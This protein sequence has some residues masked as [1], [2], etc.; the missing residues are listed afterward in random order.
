MTVAQRLYAL[1]LSVGVGFAALAA[2]DH[3]QMAEVYEEANYS[4]S[5]SLPS[6]AVLNDISQTFNTLR[7]WVSRHILHDDPVMKLETESDIAR[8]RQQLEESYS[9]YET[10][11]VDDNDRALLDNVK[12]RVGNYY[13][14]MEAILLASRAGDVA[15]ARDLYID[16]ANEGS[17]GNN[18]INELIAYNSRFA[19]DKAG[20]AHQ[21]LE[22]TNRISLVMTGLIALLMLLSGYLIVRSLMRQLGGEPAMAADV[23]NR[24]ARGDVSSEIR[25]RDGDR[26]SLMAAMH[27]MQKAIKSVI[28]E[29]M[30]VSGEYRSGN[31]AARMDANRFDGSFRTM[32]ENINSM[33][34]SQTELM[35]KVAQCLAEFSKGNFD[36]TL[37]RFPG[38]LACINAS[39]E[40]LRGNIRAVIEDLRNMSLEHDAGNID[41]RL[42]ETAFKGSF[43]EMVRGVNTMVG[44][45]VAEK[46]EMIHV[47]RALGDGD[48]TI[49]IQ[50]YP[51][52]K[53]EI[54]NNLDRLKGKLQ[55][56]LD[57]VKWVTNEH[58]QGNIDMTLHEHM[59]KGGF[60]EIAAAINT[61]VGLQMDLTEKA[62]NVVKAFG[63]GDF[64]ASLEQF[65]GK[66]AF[67]NEAIEQVRANLKA[68]NEDAQ[69]LAAAAREGRVTVRADATRHHG[70]FRKIIEGVNETLEMIV[71]PIVTVK[72]AAE[73][74]NT[75]AK[76][77][78][79]GNT[80]LSQR[81]EEQ[82]SSLEETASSMEQLASTVKQNAEN[83]K[84]ANQLAMTASSVAVK[85]G[86]V[87]QQVVGTM[88][89]INESA[90]KIE[91]IISVIDGIAFQT[92]ILA[93]N[94]AVEAARAGEQGRGFAVVAGEVRNL[95]QRSASAAKEIK[96]LI[97]DSVEKTGEGTALVEHAGKTMDEIVHSVK[98][99]A[100]IIAEIAAASVEQSTGIDQ[101]NSAVS[102]MD[103]VTQQ[104]AALVEQAAAAAES[105]MEQA[106]E[107]NTVVSVFKLDDEVQSLAVTGD[108]KVVRSAV[109]EIPA[110]RVVRPARTGTDDDDW[111]EF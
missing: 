3:Y 46:E 102:Q 95:A 75:A 26:T 105:L 17:A 10:L 100:D 15:L 39:I 66:K 99:V 61:I 49:E 18:A 110:P 9:K 56:I 92:N 45:H 59:F 64:E 109:T 74:I 69:M 70:D 85:G 42:D 84:Q 98:R 31:F 37:E 67:V 62:L 5:N 60:S 8:F 57:S 40:E 12:A 34:V 81:T 55:G 7:I 4:N 97:T 101:V 43:A 86:E 50:Q 2:I 48:F 11:I 19:Q 73:T 20:H 82:A 91:D 88:S 44:A 89:A 22:Q 58:V 33:A 76:E 36:A 30:R 71:T 41:A 90:K 104:N 93:L 79:Q 87:V 53:A 54:N 13:Q 80:D 35:Q 77:I 24:I 83:A 38:Q 25:L 94:A 111:E 78:A 28:A 72:A 29:Q 107:M 47:M 16:I 63:E 65:P 96:S 14:K 27:E 52:K 108:M 106:E 32:A 68:L 21:V 51:G 103:E 23:A 6:V 1:I